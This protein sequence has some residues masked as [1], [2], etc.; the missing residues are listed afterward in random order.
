MRTRGLHTH[1]ELGKADIAEW[2][3]MED[4]NDMVALV[5]DAMHLH[6]DSDWCAGLARDDQHLEHSH[7]C[8]YHC[9]YMHA[10]MR[11]DSMHAATHTCDTLRALCGTGG[12]TPRCTAAGHSVRGTRAGTGASASPRPGRR[13]PPQPCLLACPGPP[14]GKED[15]EAGTFSDDLPCFHCCLVVFQFV[16][17]GLC[18]WVSTRKHMPRAKSSYMAG[19]PPV[20]TVFTCDRIRRKGGAARR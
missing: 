17:R 4:M 9:M 15:I 5:T 18:P 10:C 11:A 13:P 6:F 8:T 14:P 20:H 2:S 16:T 7:A 12:R 3:W 19:S 1:R